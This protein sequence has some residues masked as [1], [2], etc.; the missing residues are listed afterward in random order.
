MN[1]ITANEAKGIYNSFS[2]SKKG[3]ELLEEIYKKIINESYNHFNYCNVKFYNVCGDGKTRNELF[4][5][6]TNLLKKDGYIVEEIYS[7]G[8]CS[9]ELAIY[10]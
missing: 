3:N 1:R 7:D 4:E 10:W 5:Y 8:L 6:I 2:V 9:I